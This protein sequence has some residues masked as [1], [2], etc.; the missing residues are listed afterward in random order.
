MLATLPRIAITMRT[1]GRSSRVRFA[2]AT[3]VMPKAKTNRLV[4]NFI[5]QRLKVSLI[6]RGVIWPLASWTAS[7]SAE[8]A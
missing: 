5:C 8:T 1:E 7:K 2:K 3:K 4:L 6:R